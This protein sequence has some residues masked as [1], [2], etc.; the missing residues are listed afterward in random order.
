MIVISDKSLCCGCS[1]CSQVCPKHCISQIVDEEG[2][3]YPSV[4]ADVCIQ[5]GLCEKVCPFLNPGESRLHPLKSYAAKNTDN[6]IRRESSSGGIFTIVA[7]QIIKEGGVVFGAKYDED[8]KVIHDY[9]EK[10]E[11]LSAFRGSKYV[12]SELGNSFGRVK[13]FLQQERKVL[14]SGTPCQIAGLKNYLLKDYNNLIT[15][16]VACHGVPSPGVWKKYLLEKVSAFNAVSEKRIDLSSVNSMSYIRDINFR[17][18]TI[19]WKKSRFVLRFAGPSRLDNKKTEL[20]SIFN[21]SEWGVPFVNNLFLRQSCHK[22]KIKKFSSG[23]D[24]TIADFWGIEKIIPL[25][26]DDQG[27]S[28][29]VV[30]TNKGLNLLNALKLDKIEVDVKDVID[31]NKAIVESYSAS[32]DRNSFFCDYKSNEPILSILKKYSK[33]LF[34]QHVKTILKNCFLYQIFRYVKDKFCRIISLVDFYIAFL[35]SFILNR[36]KYTSNAILIPADDICGGFG[37]DIMVAGFANLY[38]KPFTIG[39]KRIDNRTFFSD[40]IDKQICFT[41]HFQY[42]KFVRLLQK[43]SDLYI[44]GADILD[45]VYEI[46]KQRFRILSLSHNLGVNSHITGFSIRNNPSAF[47]IKRIK[48]ELRYSKVKARD[49]ESY[50][51]LVSILGEKNVLETVDIAFACNYNTNFVLPEVVSSWIKQQKYNGKRVIAFCPNT[52]HAKKMGLNNY[53][54]AQIQL[55]REFEKYN[56]SILFLYHDLRKYSLNINDEELSK[57]LSY[58]FGSCGL[59]VPNISD[60]YV[61]KSYIKECD[62]TVTGRMHFGISGY[63]FG[64]PMFGISYFGKFEGVQHLFGIDP[65]LSL[66]PFDN[67]ERYKSRC[68]RFV[69]EIDNYSKSVLKHINMVVEKTKLNL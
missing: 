38:R 37:E 61:M 21:Q 41:G 11:G 33:P 12:Q 48:K 7:E 66:I 31:G 8:W 45:G 54:E 64:L 63:T 30:H 9:T 2:F 69:E 22:C 20:S 44:I 28:A 25:F 53:L 32:R 62:F 39:A 67:I 23:S 65:S 10:I 14:F 59:Y 24:I 5:C 58:Y 55:L 36:D 46:N 26:D 40:N 27:T 29:V 18:K 57:M 19:G 3:M 35:L 68:G 4:D 34:I 50:N 17:D 16:D 52:I 42:V 49:V 13:Y 51:R 6:I 1:A 43:Y 56:C 47:F 60:G 15:V